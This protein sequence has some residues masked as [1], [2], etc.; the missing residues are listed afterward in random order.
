[1]PT[2]TETVRLRE[3]H[4]L[5]STMDRSVVANFDNPAA[6]AA[7]PCFVTGLRTLNKTLALHRYLLEPKTTEGMKGVLVL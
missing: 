2:N 6:A 7:D 3:R 4:P 5:F 1:M